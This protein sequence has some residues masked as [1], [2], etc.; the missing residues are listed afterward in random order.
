MNAFQ[1]RFFAACIFALVFILFY[2]ARGERLISWEHDSSPSKS[3]VMEEFWGHTGAGIFVLS[4]GSLLLFTLK[5][6]DVKVPF[7]GGE[8]A[9]YALALGIL[10]GT[11]IISWIRL[12][13]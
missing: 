9:A 1:R 12:S 3:A 13:G 11:A 10:I 6:S 8:L 5:R 7:T 2:E 4:I